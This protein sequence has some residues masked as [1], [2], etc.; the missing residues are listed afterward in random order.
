MKNYM[1]IINSEYTITIDF[2]GKTVELR[3]GEIYA[4]KELA[5]AFPEYFSETNKTLLFD[6]S[7]DV[8]LEY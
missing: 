6:N 4:D 2:K 3:N 7:S 8:Y 1:C 5:E